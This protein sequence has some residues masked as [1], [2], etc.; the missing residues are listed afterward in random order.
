LTRAIAAAFTVWQ[1]RIF[2]SSR[3]CLVPIRGFSMI[4]TAP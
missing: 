4:S 1:T 3:N 2:D